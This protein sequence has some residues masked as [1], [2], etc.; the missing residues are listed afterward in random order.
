M[1]DPIGNETVEI[2]DRTFARTVKTG[3]VKFT[4]ESISREA[5]GG[6]KMARVRADG[7]LEAL[8]KLLL[9]L[10]TELVVRDAMS[11]ETWFGCLWQVEIYKG[12]IKYGLTLD[13]FANSINVVYTQQTINQQFSG[14]GSAA[15]TGFS[16]DTASITDYGT[17]EKRI[18]SG[19]LSSTAAQA[20]RAKELANRA[21][22]QSIGITATTGG[23]AVYAVITA[24]GWKKTLGVRFY[25]NDTGN[26]AGFESNSVLTSEAAQ[27]LG[28]G[29]NFTS[30]QFIAN[31]EI[32]ATGADSG[33]LNIATSSYFFVSD[34]VSNNKTWTVTSTPA[35]PGSNA[36][37]TPTNVANEAAGTA[38]IIQVGTKIWQTFELST[39]NPFYAAAVDIRSH[40]GNATDDLVI[41]IY[42]VSGGLP[43]SLLATGTITNAELPANSLGWVTAV[44]SSTTL[45]SFGTIYG[46]LIERSSGSFT[47]GTAFGIGVDTALSYTRGSMQ[48]YTDAT[49]GWKSRPVNADLIF[50][51]SGLVETTTQIDTVVSSVG[52]FF[53]DV[54]IDNASGLRT[55]P[56]RDGTETAE[57]VVRQLQAAGTSNN[58]RLLSKVD[59][60]GNGRVLVLF[61][62]PSSTSAAAFRLR[63]DGLLYTLGGELIPPHTLPCGQWATVDD[64]VLAQ[65]PSNQVFIDE[66]E[67]SP[68]RGTFR[69]V[70]TR[71]RAS[72]FEIGLEL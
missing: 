44:L 50:K 15:E 47:S 31:S 54:Q 46:I 9:H 62:E 13:G 34:T 69:I 49:N 14:A 38:N 63:D 58:K 6:S 60:V 52:E 20:E 35:G 66:V 72:E 22:P 48:L 10:R 40:R 39:D 56:Y 28:Q 71:D 32:L 68:Q 45:I 51:V 55:L 53:S 27:E 16:S 2:R 29:E 12:K 33:R 65:A 36:L 23:D 37:V 26:A 11:V 61:E 3:G 8:N 17:F 7:S 43:D 19:N 1:R 59:R 30:I 18:R 4:V 24:W 25:E 21:K 67:W 64:L 70:R 57:Q 42:S 5:D 41:S